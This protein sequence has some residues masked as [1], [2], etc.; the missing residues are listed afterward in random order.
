MTNETPESTDRSIVLQLR[1]ES[2]KGANLPGKFETESSSDA[3][4]VLRAVAIID[5]VIAI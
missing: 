1:R 3:M 2:G 5:R 4:D